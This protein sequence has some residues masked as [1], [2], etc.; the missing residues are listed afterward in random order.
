[1]WFLKT[2]IC[3]VQWLFFHRASPSIN[4]FVAAKP[5]LN[6]SKVSVVA[7]QFSRLHFSFNETV[8]LC[9]S[10]S[11]CTRI[12]STAIYH[13]LFLTNELPSADEY[14]TFSHWICISSLQLNTARKPL[15]R[16]I[17]LIRIILFDFCF[18]LKI[19]DNPKSIVI[20]WKVLLSYNPILY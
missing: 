16:R 1:M 20:K 8:R 13:H 5:S 9:C 11:D 10:L 18:R 17:A 3:F 15:I 14:Y 7:V 19:H 12:T 6:I 4:H 2:K